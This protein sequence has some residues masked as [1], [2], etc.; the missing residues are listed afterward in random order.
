MTA[1]DGTIFNTGCPDQDFKY[2]QLY[3]E[4]SN[5]NNNTPVAAT[6][7]TLTELVKKF[8]KN[9][10][11]SGSWKEPKTYSQL[12]GRLEKICKLSPNKPVNAYTRD[13][14]RDIREGILN[15]QFQGK[16]IEATTASKYLKLLIE[17]INFGNTEQLI[18]TAVFNKLFIKAKTK[19]KGALTDHHFNAIFNGY[20][21][22]YKSPPENVSPKTIYPYMF[23]IPLI[24]AYSGFRVGEAAALQ[25][26]DINQCPTSLVYY[27]KIRDSKTESG[28]RE[29]PM[30]DA[31]FNAGF[32]DFYKERKKLGITAMLFEG[33]EYNKS[34]KWSKN[35][36]DW[37]N[38]K[39][40]GKVI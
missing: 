3:T 35:P 4:A 36:S 15:I 14:A 6:G 33:I 21:Y 27:F 16:N 22:K 11:D 13:D 29:V 40:R 34:N 31:I 12:T 23:W 28:V 5:K 39:K 19:S 20:I 38:G 7:I 10:E 1:P 24:C 37:F 2:L 8:I 32:M 26:Q 25:V 18:N 30:H 17:V 9:K